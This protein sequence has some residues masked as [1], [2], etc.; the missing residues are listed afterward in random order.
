MLPLFILNIRN[1]FLVHYAF[2]MIFKISFVFILK[3][4][5]TAFHFRER[6]ACG[7]GGIGSPRALL[8]GLE[9]VDI[10]HKFL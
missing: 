8:R 6:T 4:C 5:F 7:A 9:G 2:Y 1:D 3:Q 10:A